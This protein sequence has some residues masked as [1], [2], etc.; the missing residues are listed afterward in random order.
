MARQSS[1]ARETT[2]TAVTQARGTTQKVT[3]LGKTAR[4][5]GKVTEAITEISEMTNLLALNATIEAARAG[6]AGK[7]FAVVAD[8]IKDLAG[9][10]A[11]AN[12]EIRKMIADI[13]GKMSGDI[14]EINLFSD[15][16]TCAGTEIQKSSRA[17]S[18]L[19]SQLKRVVA[20][21]NV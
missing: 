21:F 12:E 19:S 1:A 5:I 16:M 6:A 2:G 13:T 18:T 14:G 8:E 15:N 7:G 10:S 20:I 9:Q 17:L 11:R 4:E 3:W